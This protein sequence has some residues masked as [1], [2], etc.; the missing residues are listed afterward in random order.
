MTRFPL[1]WG[2]APIW[3]GKVRGKQ[4]D[5]S[6]PATNGRF[7][8]MILDLIL[9]TYTPPSKLLEKRVHLLRCF[10][11]SIAAPPNQK[12]HERPS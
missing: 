6:S 12:R 3:V 5:H 8:I 7:H 1:S 11:H 4:N 9:A 10:W 2:L